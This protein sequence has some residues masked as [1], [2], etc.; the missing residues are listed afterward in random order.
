MGDY[1]ARAIEKKMK[2][3][4]F[5]D[6]VDLNRNDYGY[7]YYDP[8]RFFKKFAEWKEKQ[9]G[10]IELLAGIEFGEPHLYGE[11]LQELSGYAYDM[12]IGSIHWVGDMFPCRQVREKY[13]AKEFYTMY[14][15]VMLKTVKHGGFDVLGHIDFPKRYY[16][17]I[18][19]EEP[20]LKEIFKHLLERN[21]VIEI[22]TSSLR[23]GC[24]DTMPG[25]EL[26][27]IYKGVGGEY[28]TI[29]S[30]AHVVDDLNAGYQEARQR[31]EQVGLREVR[32]V[33][34]KQMPVE[35]N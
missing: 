4:C 15:N 7:N 31:M 1:V 24:P 28:I 25:I 17:E 3:I 5:T 12:I 22:N 32:Y 18:Y 19:Y 27:E 2:T 29:G 30:D 23:K 6:H 8:E 21:A 34:R 9:E 11:R 35:E 10:K 26:L 33:D 13:S 14:W 20:I 16:N